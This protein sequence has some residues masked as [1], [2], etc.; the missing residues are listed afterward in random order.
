VASA[1]LLAAGCIAA[2]LV[3]GFV[4]YRTGYEMSLSAFYLL[5][6]AVITWFL[7]ARWGI[8]LSLFSSAVQWGINLAPEAVHPHGLIPLWNAAIYAV[9]YLVVVGL[10]ACLRS[11]HEE[12]EAR[13]RERTLALSGEI[14]R[15]KR[16]EMELIGAGERE[17]RRIGRDLHDGLCQHLAGTALSGQVIRGSLASGGFGVAADELGRMVSLVEEAIVM[18]RGIAR[19]LS[20]VDLDDEGLAIALREMAERVS[21]PGNLD[22]LFLMEEPVRIGDPDKSI[23]LF[24]IA[25]E[26]IGNAIRH[27][28][29]G[30]LTIHL[31]GDGR[32]VMLEVSDDGCGMPDPLPSDRG[33]GL[34]IMRQRAS[35]IGATLEIVHEKRGT[36]IRCRLDVGGVR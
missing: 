23:H 9:S 31:S 20:P 13:V 11:T 22:C 1:R 19:G 5:P 2:L 29:A 21:G 34:Q 12:L 36:T 28:G 8:A 3:I 35:M 6:I 33:M 17:Q 27:A 25:Q 15:R 10:T 26:A 14:E 30:Y 18:A 7:G 24:R 32:D 4:D 16:L